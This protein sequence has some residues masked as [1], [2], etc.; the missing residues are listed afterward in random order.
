MVPL[1]LPGHHDLTS[2]EW[3]G[4]AAVGDGSKGGGGEGGGGEGGGEGGAA[5]IH[6]IHE[7]RITL[8]KVLRNRR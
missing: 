8:E 6:A 1:A 3:R 7:K 2:R 4:T 5:A